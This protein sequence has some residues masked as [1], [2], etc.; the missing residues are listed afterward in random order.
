MVRK[1]H[2]R[3][4]ADVVDV[5]MGGSYKATS[6]PRSTATTLRTHRVV[7]NTHTLNSDTRYVVSVPAASDAVASATPSAATATPGK[8]RKRATT[9]SD[10]VSLSP[11]PAF[12]KSH[13]HGVRHWDAGLGDSVS[14]LPQGGGRRPVAPLGATWRSP[15]Q[16]PTA[17]RARDAGPLDGTYG[18]TSVGLTRSW[19]DAPQPPLQ[20]LEVESE[21]AP[22][23]PEA[24]PVL[25]AP[26]AVIGEATVDPSLS[27]VALTL[28]VQQPQTRWPQWPGE[29]PRY[30]PLAA[31]DASTGEPLPAS[32]LPALVPRRM[33]MAQQL[34][35][36]GMD[37]DDWVLGTALPALVATTNGQPPAAQ[38]SEQRPA[39]RSLQT[40]LFSNP[41]DH[42]TPPSRATDS[43]PF[44]ARIITGRPAGMHNSA[45]QRISDQFHLL[46]PDG[47]LA[48]AAS[49]GPAS[50]LPHA[51]ASSMVTVSDILQHP[52]FAAPFPRNA[53]ETATRV[54]KSQRRAAQ[55]RSLYNETAATTS[56]GRAAASSTMFATTT[57]DAAQAAASAARA[58]LP[59]E[60]VGDAAVRSKV[61]AREQAAAAQSEAEAK[62]KEEERRLAHDS[63]R[64]AATLA[65]H[66]ASELGRLSIWR[67]MEAGTAATAAAAI[68]GNDGLLHR[69]G[70]GGGGRMPQRP[71]VPRGWR[72]RGA[73][74]AGGG[75][76]RAG[77]R[78]LREAAIVGDD[79]GRVQVKPMPPS[80]LKSNEA[81]MATAALTAAA[82]RH[83]QLGRGG[84]GGGSPAR[85][86]RPR[87]STS[88]VTR[89]AQE[90]PEIEGPVGGTM[91]VI[92][93]Q[94]EVRSLVA[95]G[96]RRDI[97]GILGRKRGKRRRKPVEWQ[98][99]FVS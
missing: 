94:R 27:E 55:K 86:R 89:E 16:Q 91:G 29:D 90:L 7:T 76:R 19:E 23:T 67:G 21:A 82:A 66:A 63:V 50:S 56:A 74:R 28:G 80:M 18:A 68:S 49:A 58:V 52:G 84:N 45:A 53:T 71:Q 85:R 40:V 48:K 97:V 8:R 22:P 5:A 10:R 2:Q 75:G 34:Q 24:E 36:A 6:A 73:G 65:V 26:A 78:R 44:P 99:F 81:R 95:Q 4:A 57:R 47:S 87:R 38:E 43:T 15:L 33:S 62:A 14:G 25:Q 11:V 98:G 31:V 20:S 35:E 60:Q 1:W 93:R 12:A 3:R 42:V 54:H 61:A 46:W 96:R 32:G 30:A 88:P 92:R 69:S 83:K 72:H 79:S 70:G 13:S 9:D 77:G 17:T 51:A 59:P 37:G 41:F 39:Q 64:K